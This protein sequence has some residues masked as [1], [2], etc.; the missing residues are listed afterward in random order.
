M[1]RLEIH[2]DE[3]VLRGL[4]QEYADQLRLLVGQRL[5]ELAQRPE[6]VSSRQTQEPIADAGALAD[7]VARHVL[8]QID[9]STWP[10]AASA[11]GPKAA[12]YRPPPDVTQAST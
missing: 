12:A 3:L 11:E 6:V 5:T 2:I 10:A 1:T 8:A 7:L 9:T 4:P